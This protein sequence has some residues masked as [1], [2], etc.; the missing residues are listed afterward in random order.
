MHATQSTSDVAGGGSDSLSNSDRRHRCHPGFFSFELLLKD[1][2]STAGFSIHS[3]LINVG[4]CE[5]PSIF[6]MVGAS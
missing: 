6:K 3:F 2:V 4:S 1:S 5:L